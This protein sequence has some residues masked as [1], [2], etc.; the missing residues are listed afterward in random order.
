MVKVFN[1]NSGLLAKVKPR[2]NMVI[3]R[4]MVGG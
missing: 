2:G 4:I 1:F 3:N